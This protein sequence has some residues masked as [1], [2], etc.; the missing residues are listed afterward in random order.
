M[1]RFNSDGSIGERTIRYI[2][3]KKYAIIYICTGGY[4]V[5]WKDFY[6]SSEKFFLTGAR[7]EYFVFTDAKEL[8]QNK[9]DRIHSFY[10]GKMG[11]PYDTLLRWD[12][13]CA[14][15]DLLAEYDYIVFCNANMEFLSEIPSH[16]FEDTD[17]TLWSS[18]KDLD[19]AD[20]LPL[21]RRPES[22]AYIPYGTPVKKYVAGGYILGRSEPFLR[23][24]RELRDWTAQDLQNGIIP[25]WHDESLENAY[26]YHN[27]N[28]VTVKI[29]GPELINME[30]FVKDRKKPCAIF[31][32]KDRY[33]G[34]IGI[35]YNMT[36]GKLDILRRK[37]MGKL[38][39]G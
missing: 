34:N 35:R 18:T 4:S 5:F 23:M 6:D 30:E 9:D 39:I 14:I 11:W 27:R 8:I 12:R 28:N 2:R 31:R 32:N 26:F 16:I 10:C 17:F 37:I 19:S 25:I 7:K 1:T 15:Q 13:I 22:R 33:G 20:Q 24:S 3:M 38:R 36:L 29:I 21:E